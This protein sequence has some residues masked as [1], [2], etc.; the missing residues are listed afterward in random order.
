MLLTITKWERVCIIA[1][2]A[3]EVINYTNE[4]LTVLWFFT[5]LNL[6]LPF[7]SATLE[8]RRS[9]MSTLSGSQKTGTKYYFH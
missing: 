4:S 5:L 9:G 2:L 6:S 3:K 7:V 8:N 1:P